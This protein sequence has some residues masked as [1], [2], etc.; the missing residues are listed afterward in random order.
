M[1]LREIITP[2][3]SNT[4]LSIRQREF[5]L[6]NLKNIL[7]SKPKE[8]EA[9]NKEYEAYCTASGKHK[10][11]NTKR[12]LSSVFNYK[13][14]TRTN[15]RYYCGYDLAKKLNVKTCPYCNRNY[16]V[17]IAEGR[18][19]IARPDFDHFF[20]H[21]QYPLLALS[22]YNLIPSC[23]ICNRTLKNQAKI[24]Y[25]KYIH[26]Y[27]EGYGNALKF[28]YFANDVDSSVGIKTNYEIET[29]NDPFE[30][31]KAKKCLESFNLFKLKEIYKESHNGEIADIVRKHYISNGK[32]LEILNIAFPSLGGI[33]ELYRIAFGNYYFEDEFEKRPLS[34][35]T[36]D[37]V[38]QLAFTILK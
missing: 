8:L 21:K 10:I 37:V 1:A 6:E 9:I 27:E 19:K 22:F 26:P 33:D 18:K 24:V 35:L 7:V 34:K 36:K 15:S 5:I 23:S 11:K 32:Y 4:K 17:T 2:N 14:F 3:L 20:P 31:L 29:I 25:G 30:P 13:W 38:E 12:G 28:N 16:T